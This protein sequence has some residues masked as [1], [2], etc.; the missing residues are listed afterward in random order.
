[1]MRRIVLAGRQ[2]IVVLKRAGQSQFDSAPFCEEFSG[3]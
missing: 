3:G 2:Q 1:M